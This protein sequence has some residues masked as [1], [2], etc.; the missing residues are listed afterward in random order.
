MVMKEGDIIQSRYRLVSLK[1]R[2]SFG[3]VWL[4]KDEQTDL[5]VAVKVYIALDDKGLEE[6]KAEYKNSYSLNHPNLLHAY[7]FDVVDRQPF[8]VMPY[9]PDS[10]ESLV[11]N[12][13]EKTLLRFIRDVASGLEYLHARDIIHRD[14]KPDNILVNQEGN[15]VITDFGVSSKMKSTLRRNS[16][17]AMAGADVAGT[18]GYMGP[19]LFSRNP[20]AVKATDIWAL[21]ATIYE[22]AAGEMPFFGKGGVMLMS[23]ATI[24]E[25]V[26][27]Y[28]DAFKN[29]I[30]KCLEKETWD[31]P[32]AGRLAAWS[33]SLLK[34]ESVP[35]LKIHNASK[36]ESNPNQTVRHTTGGALVEKEVKPV[37]QEA[38]E[39]PAKPDAHFS[40]APPTEAKSHKGKSV[41]WI[42]V[43]MALVVAG[44][45]ISTLPK[46]DP[47]KKGKAVP[48]QTTP[49]K[50]TAKPAE[51]KEVT[52][53][54]ASS[55]TIKET[56]AKTQE[57][58][59]QQPDVDDRKAK[60]QAALKK[61][62][63]AT[64]KSLADGGFGQASLEMAKHYLKDPSK[65][66]Q[67]EKYA[68]K[69]KNAGFRKGAQEVLDGLRA[70]GYYD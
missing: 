7:Y 47:P 35:E 42:G 39:K 30:Y 68:N 66:D 25:I 50:S 70:M 24:P 28:S 6:F 46:K 23:G 44:I 13:D 40:P 1:G 55:P 64:V 16:T 27:D 21:G 26:G 11:G 65:H 61:G 49:Q 5:D 22:M 8:L 37:I 12:A 53:K 33:E 41:A 60:L 58:K 48:V 20:D 57:Q 59:T 56:P 32:T 69:A 63:Y 4:A 43:L 34:G 31:R 36:N 17:R 52:T 14:I 51:K 10:A 15:F 67:A 45:V 62:D 9:C 3:E 18:I 54:P 29:L 38:P 2:G 19:E